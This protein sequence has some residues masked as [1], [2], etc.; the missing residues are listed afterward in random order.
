MTGPDRYL[1]D[2]TDAFEIARAEVDDGVRIGDVAVLVG[3][4]HYRGQGSG[5]LSRAMAPTWSERPPWFPRPTSRCCSLA[6]YI[7]YASSSPTS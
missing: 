3:R 7:A 5:C 1:S 2:L 4:I 6:A